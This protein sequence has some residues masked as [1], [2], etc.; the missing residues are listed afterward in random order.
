M[1]LPFSEHSLTY[2]GF[3]LS[4]GFMHG[5]S[6]PCW[7]L[8]PHGKASPGS[9]RAC[10]SP[11]LQQTAACRAQRV[12]EGAQKEEERWDGSCSY[13]FDRDL[14]LGDGCWHLQKEEGLREGW[15][16][17]SCVP[18]SA[19]SSPHMGATYL[20]ARVSELPGN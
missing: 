3:P 18:P 6:A 2:S 11:A 14:H 20:P 4:T 15:A 7:T 1:D 13:P 12:S 19:S 5:I 10:C 17:A 8:E 16:G 9:P